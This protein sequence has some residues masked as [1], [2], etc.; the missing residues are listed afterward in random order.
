MDEQKPNVAEGTVVGPYVLETRVGQ[1]GFGEV[2]TARH[3]EWEDRVEAFKF[4]TDPRFLERLRSEGKVLRTLTHPN[5]VEI[6]D[7]DTGC[8]TPYIRMEYVPGRS[9]ED[10]LGEGPPLSPEETLGI[11]RQILDALEYAH[12]RGVVHRDLKPGNVILGEDGTVKL[13]DFGIAAVTSEISRALDASLD[14][15]E[16][17]KTS[18]AGTL[19]YMAPEQKR[20][21]PPAPPAD[22]YSLGVMIYRM[23]AGRLP[24]SLNPPSHFHSEVPDWLDRVVA[25]ML[26]PVE[27]RYRSAAEIRADMDRAG[28]AGGALLQAAG[29]RA[30]SERWFP[31][32]EVLYG[33]PVVGCVAC[34]TNARA[35]SPAVSLT[36]AAVLG[37]L[38]VMAWRYSRAPV[39]AGALWAGV[40]FAVL[41]GRLHR[42][43]FFV[44][45]AMA[46]LGAV[47]LLA[48]LFLPSPERGEEAPDE[49]EK[50]AGIENRE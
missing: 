49:K 31:W 37:A 12:G 23:L 27:E 7:I 30:W 41:G 43:F 18:M 33:M 29:P 42:G 40:V 39:R 14:T 45:I 24:H 21:E 20:G 17:Q 8:T 25:G 35:V 44:G 3:R 6:R 15:L 34:I 26:D 48:G 38:A 4:P 19:D 5:I 46:A 9:L 11:F 13:T 47:G 2:W 50:D 1:G 28:F 16:A 22:I 10:R 32:G 36:L